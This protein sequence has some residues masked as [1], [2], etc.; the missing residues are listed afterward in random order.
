M[1][2]VHYTLVPLLDSSLPSSY[3]PICLLC[4][5][6]VHLLH[7]PKREQP[8]AQAFSP[9]SVDCHFKPHWSVR[10]HLLLQMP[11]SLFCTCARRNQ[12]QYCDAS[13]LQR[14]IQ[15]LRPLLQCTAEM[16]QVS[17]SSLRVPATACL[18][19]HRC[20]SRLMRHAPCR[21]CLLPRV[22]VNV[23]SMLLGPMRGRY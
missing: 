5:P 18:Q 23:C 6:S 7:L 8:A 13:P 15:C 17:R 16:K 3:L 22:G 9:D 2:G 14:A 11:L 1:Q 21:C 10:P 19:H 20:T 4:P 12:L